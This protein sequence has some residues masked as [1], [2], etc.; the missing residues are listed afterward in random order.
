MDK[1]EYKIQ[2]YLAG[3]SVDKLRSLK[4]MVEDDGSLICDDKSYLL[5]TIS[6]IIGDIVDGYLD[7]I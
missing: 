7:Q 1:E 4:S 3:R 2:I 6:Q 5:R